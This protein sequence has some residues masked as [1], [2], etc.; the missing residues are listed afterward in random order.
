MK[1]LL[2]LFFIS[3]SIIGLN[4]CSKKDA[5]KNLAEEV[6]KNRSYPFYSCQTG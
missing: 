5:K 2:F 1:Q 4:S 6:A 3:F